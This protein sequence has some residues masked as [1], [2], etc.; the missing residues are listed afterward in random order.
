MKMVVVVH[1]QMRKVNGSVFD[2]NG[3]FQD[4]LTPPMSY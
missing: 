4:K 3:V 2:K 1:Y